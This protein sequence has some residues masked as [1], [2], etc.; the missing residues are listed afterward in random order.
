MARLDTSGLDDLIAEM[1]RMGQSSGD[2]AEAMV[3]AA[4]VVIRDAWKETAEKY[5]L[6]DTGDMIRSIGFPT[7]PQK[8]GAAI[9]RDVYPQGKDSKGVR[10]AE[11]AFLLHYGT[12]RI[13]AKYWVDEA[14]AISGPRVQERLEEIWGEFLETGK[15]PTTI[16]S[17]VEANDEG[18]TTKTK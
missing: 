15:I 1:E 7:P 9:F 12:S 13:K 5:G 14:E 6:H 8:I 17:V 16:D 4:A 2:V 11:K 10:N 3:N 18:I